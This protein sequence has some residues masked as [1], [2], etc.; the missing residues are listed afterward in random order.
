MFNDLFFAVRLSA[1]LAFFFHLAFQTMKRYVQDYATGQQEPFV[2]L[3]ARHE[4]LAKPP[5]GPFEESN[6][7]Y[8]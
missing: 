5:L 1:L 4:R 8:Y 7:T 2:P 3:F 6:V